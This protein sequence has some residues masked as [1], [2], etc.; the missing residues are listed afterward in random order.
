MQDSYTVGQFPQPTDL[1]HVFMSTV[2]VAPMASTSKD[3]DTTAAAPVA[4]ASAETGA[5]A[6]AGCSGKARSGPKPAPTL[7][8]QMGAGFKAGWADDMV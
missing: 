6:A 3:A 4:G 8:S 7:L 5:S 1:L 2:A